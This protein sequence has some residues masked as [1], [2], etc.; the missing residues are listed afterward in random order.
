MSGFGRLGSG[1]MRLGS[2]ARIALII[3]SGIVVFALLMVLRP[4]P[5]SQEPPRRT[6]I[7]VTAPADVQSGNLTIRVPGGLLSKRPQTAPL[8]GWWC[9][10][11]KGTRLNPNSNH[12]LQRLEI[13][14]E[15]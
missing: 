7:V 2:F 15:A 5:Q 6:P 13:P 8:A 1:I 9:G 11:R 12:P 3:G 10:T 4:R 14:M